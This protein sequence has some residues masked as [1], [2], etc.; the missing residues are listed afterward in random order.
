[1]GRSCP[2]PSPVLVLNAAYSDSVPCRKYSKPWR[3]AR[4]G[5]SGST[6]SL[7]SSA[8]IARLLVHAEHR[9]ML[10]RVQIQADHVGR[11]GLE[12]RIVGGEVALPADAA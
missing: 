4:P 8:W 10:R 6:G 2:A 3:S 7:R 12:V 11:L 5:D 9:R 1:M